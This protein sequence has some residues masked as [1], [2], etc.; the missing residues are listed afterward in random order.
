MY[1]LKDIPEP[2]FHL[3]LRHQVYID[4]THVGFKHFFV[5]AAVVGYHLFTLMHV[6]NLSYF[7]ILNVIVINVCFKLAF[8]VRLVQNSFL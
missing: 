7:L 5:Q 1:Q 4:Q 6:W 2:V 3:A 8:R